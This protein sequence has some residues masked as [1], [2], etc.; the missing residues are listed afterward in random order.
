MNPTQYGLFQGPENVKSADSKIQATL[1][2]QASLA[3]LLIVHPLTEVERKLKCLRGFLG[4][5][6]AEDPHDL[7]SRPLKRLGGKS[8][9][10][11]LPTH[12]DLVQAFMQECRLHPEEKK[13][14]IE[15]E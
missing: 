6:F 9:L 4:L 7:V 3:E 12:P 8:L 5:H 15:K 2:E 11:V 1:E 13:L 14:L 10:E